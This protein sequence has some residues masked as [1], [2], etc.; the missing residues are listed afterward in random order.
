LLLGCTFALLALDPHLG[1]LVLNWLS[2]LE[3]ELRLQFSLLLL[4]H[5]LLEDVESFWQGLLDVFLDELQLKN[6]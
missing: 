2:D 5:L 4:L 6:H 1:I 3:L